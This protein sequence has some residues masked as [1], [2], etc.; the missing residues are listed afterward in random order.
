MRIGRLLLCAL[1]MVVG[2]RIA[3]AADQEALQKVK[4]LYAAAAYE[5]VLAMI[6]ALPNDARVP[7]VDQYRAFCLIALGQTEQAQG[8]IEK[9]VAADPSYMPDPAEMSPRVLEVFNA[10]RHRVLPTVAKRLYT[11]A[12]VSLDRK[13]RDDAVAR[14]EQLLRV[15][16]SAGGL[17]EFSDLRVLASGFLDLSRALPA[18][19]MPAP[20]P[21]EAPVEAS[22]A[23][24]P[25]PTASTAPKAIKQDLPRW[26]PFDN[27][28]RLN[29][30]SGAIRV[31]VGPDGKVQKAEMVRRTHPSYDALLLERA[32]SWTYEPAMKDGVAISAD[33]VVEVRLQPK[34]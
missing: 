29:E 20:A 31:R 11:D 34:E 12:K 1:M 13:D 5:D 4:A 19:K 2:A 15:I 32:R 24:A 7:N 25:V 33:V 17:A 6:T 30:F 18:T 14:F 8:V 10:T 28:T 16:D 23:S 21:V 27:L 26:S 9:L 3:W 22:T